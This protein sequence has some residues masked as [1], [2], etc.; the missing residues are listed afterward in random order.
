MRALILLSFFL[1]A[2]AWAGDTQF[3]GRWNIKVPHES[4]NR[5]WWLE[6]EGAGA[7]GPLIGRFGGFPGGNTDNIP[8]LSIHGGELTSSADRNKQRLVYHARLVGDKLEGTY[9]PGKDKLEWTGARAPVRP[10]KDDGSWRPGKPVKLFDGKTLH[11]RKP[12]IPGQPL[13]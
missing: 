1:M 9:E 8:Q 11:G 6:V 5:V 7:G 4:K 10:E 2:T 13:T 12:L 3:N